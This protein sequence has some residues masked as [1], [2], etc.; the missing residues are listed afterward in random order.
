MEENKKPLSAETQVLIYMLDR[1]KESQSEK[2]RASV[3]SCLKAAVVC[4]P[5]HAV[6][7][8]RPETGADGRKQVKLT[9]KMLQTPD[10][11]KFFPVFSTV[12]QI[13]EPMRK[14]I[15]VANLP[16]PQVVKM[17]FAGPEIDGMVVD[18][19]S[20][21]VQLSAEELKEQG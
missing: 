8:S 4:V 19:Y 13:P 16:F 7:G 5:V 18:A 15:G 1:Y 2:D 17:A 20:H 14:G 6:D 11:R 3:L 10:G 9:V 21:N 12:D